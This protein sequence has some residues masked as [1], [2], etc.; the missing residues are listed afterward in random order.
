MEFR[1][2]VTI[3]LYTRQQ[4][5]HRYIEQTFGLI[6]SFFFNFYFYF[7]LQYCIGFAIRW[8]ESAMGVHEFPILKPLPP[9]SPY[10][11]S[12]SSQCTSPKHPISCIK[13]RLV[14]HFLHDSIHVSMP[15]S[16]IIPPLLLPQSP[17]VCSKHLCLFCCL[18]YRVIITIFLNSIYMC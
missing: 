6:Y 15:F 3:T 17:K 12:G 14:I 4:K 8:H 1:K 13:P 7:I 9:P 18:T 11:L 5:R 16:Q 2:M 10:Y